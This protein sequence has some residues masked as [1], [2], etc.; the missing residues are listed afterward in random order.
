MCSNLAP[1]QNCIQPYN[2]GGTQ[3]R[4]MV[5]QSSVLYSL[6]SCV[7]DDHIN[8]A[9]NVV[10]GSHERIWLCL[11]TRLSSF[12][13]THTHT[14]LCVH[15]HTHSRTNFKCTLTHAHTHTHTHTHTA[16]TSP[17]WIPARAAGEQLQDVPGYTTARNVSV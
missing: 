14:H 6:M 11:H 1:S 13:H 17:S 12:P 5:V 8:V 10:V 7:D 4:S 15:T 3:Y 16:L 9:R 2:R